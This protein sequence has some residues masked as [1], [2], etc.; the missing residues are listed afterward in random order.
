MSPLTVAAMGVHLDTVQLLLDN[1]V[2]PT[3]AALWA[4]LHKFTYKNNVEIV[5]ALL[6]KAGAFSKH[7][8]VTR[9]WPVPLGLRKEFES[10]S[11]TPLHFVGRI[12]QLLDGGDDTIDEDELANFTP[13]S[14]R[15]KE[16]SKMLSAAIDEY[17]SDQEAAAA[18]SL[19]PPAI[20]PP[21]ASI[22]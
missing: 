16:I 22:L 6:E 17:V 3:S 7:V 5:S 14:S 2:K 9:P 11:V 21:S 20:P 4:I 10:K 12:I 13:M 8:L 18:A 1:G 19:P 15:L